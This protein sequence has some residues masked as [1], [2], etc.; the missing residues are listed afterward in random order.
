MFCSICKAAASDEFQRKGKFDDR[1]AARPTYSYIFQGGWGVK[2]FEFIISI[3]LTNRTIWGLQC[4]TAGSS[5]CS[6]DVA[7][8]KY[9]EAHKSKTFLIKLFK[10]NKVHPNYYR[11]LMQQF[12]PYSNTNLEVFPTVPGEMTSKSLSVFLKQIL[13]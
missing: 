2:Y 7:S 1:M 12:L 5:A 13:S 10:L 3:S 6:T 8:F 4:L 9:E 11:P